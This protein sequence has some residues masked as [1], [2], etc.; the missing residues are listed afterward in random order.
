MKI[1][2][3]PTLDLTTIL[4]VLALIGQGA[5]VLQRV[6]VLEEGQ[7]DLRLTIQTYAERNNDAHAALLAN[8]AKTAAI[9]DSHIDHS[10]N[11]NWKP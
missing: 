10:K 9:L 3:N 8:A 5:V 4:T 2:F 1:N 7:K 6:K 11:L